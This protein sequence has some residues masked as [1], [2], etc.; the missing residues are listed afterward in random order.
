MTKETN[1]SKKPTEPR[2]SSENDIS[3]L[4]FV[5]PSATDLFDAQKHI[6]AVADDVI[7][8]FDTSVLLLPYQVD[9]QDLSAIAA[10]FE[11]LARKE[12]IFVPARVVREF[13]KLRDQKLASMVQTLNDM[14]SRLYS[15]SKQLLPL[16]ND[17]PDYKH[18]SECLNTLI[19]A[20]NAFGKSLDP[21]IEEVKNWRGDDPVSKIYK[22]TFTPERI[23]EHEVG[24]Q[25]IRLEFQKRV[26]G[27]VPPGYKDASKP[28][29]GIGDFIIWKSLLQMG[30]NHKKDLVFV[31]GEEKAD[32][33]IRSNNKPIYPRPELVYEYRR[34]S[35][36]MT[37]R[38]CSLHEL[39]QEM[40]APEGVVGDVKSAEAE[41]RFVQASILQQ[42]SSGLVSISGPRPI[43]IPGVGFDYS[44]NNGIIEVSQYDKV[45]RLRFSTCSDT[46]IY[47]YCSNNLRRIARVN[48][49]AGCSIPKESLDW[50]SDRYSVAKG[51]AFFAENVDGDV[52]VGRLDD[53]QD[54]TRSASRDGVS[55]RYNVQGQSNMLV[56]F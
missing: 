52:L 56:T 41:A 14:K 33:F 32:W 45:F 49:F 11:L 29:G 30:K 24:E 35:S 34:A 19:R 18:A 50:T 16:L 12:R 6:S 36:G 15:P 38:L 37:I 53:I 10:V 43:V 4:E 55:F 44:T 23:I 28:D 47:F 22:K 9:G 40:Q 46:H 3:V 7:V 42:T 25:D 5:Y 20:N 21:L 39:L 27:K 2:A 31:T 48:V 13:I 54:S 17:L 8:A 51:D 26:D 1:T